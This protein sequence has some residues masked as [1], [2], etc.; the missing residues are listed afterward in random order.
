VSR[1]DSRKETVSHDADP[2]SR[3]M[4]RHATRDD[5]LCA[6][7]TARRP[8]LYESG[9][10][11]SLD[12]PAHVR[13]AS[14]LSIVGRGLVVIQDD[15][16]F[17]GALR[18][19]DDRVGAVTLP[20]GREGKRQF[21][22]LRGNKRFKLDLESSVSIEHDGEAVLYA[23]GSGSSAAREHV[24]IARGWERGPVAIEVIEARA[25]YGALRAVA[26]FAGSEL[27]VEGVALRG[28]DLWLFGRGNGAARGDVMPLNATCVVPWTTVL[29][30]LA[31]RDDSAVPLP[32]RITRYDLGALDGIP[33]GF[34]D[35]AALPN[36]FLYS[37]AAEDSPDAVRDGPVAG[38]AL[39]IIDLDRDVR[40]TPL[41]NADGSPFTGKVEGVAL[42][43]EEPNTLLAVTDHDDP[44]V[45]S[46]LCTIALEG[47]W[48]R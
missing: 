34:T 10:D 36:G 25:L 48:L 24:V 11:A 33:L 38:S 40:W 7:I 30:C 13:A 14:S 47:N 27:N 26:G 29:E 39:G 37:A 35:A 2:Q 5:G 45:P 15:A 8:L 46:E 42:S 32:T 3:E 16:N 23:F 1:D 43:P 17:L 21:D 22:D 19:A 28:D 9:A 12:R 18:P 44:R 41:M 4:T 20:A 6:I 31:S